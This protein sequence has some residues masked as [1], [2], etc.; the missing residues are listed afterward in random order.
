M[1]PSVTLLSGIE[2]ALDN[3]EEVWSMKVETEDG[4]E[5]CQGP[6]RDFM[7]HQLYVRMVRQHHPP[8]PSPP[9]SPCP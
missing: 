5:E 6:D 7:I 4:D 2:L 8:S 3:P 9:T 1:N